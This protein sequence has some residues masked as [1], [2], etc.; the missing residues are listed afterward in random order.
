LELT[1]SLSVGITPRH[2]DPNA[3][4]LSS[5]RDGFEMSAE[6]RRLKDST[7]VDNNASGR[8]NNPQEEDSS[9]DHV[10]REERGRVDKNSSELAAQRARDIANGREAARRD[11]ARDPSAQKQGTPQP[12]VPT[13]APLIVRTSDGRAV[14]GDA[15]AAKSVFY[16]AP[17]SPRP[18]MPPAVVPLRIIPPQSAFFNPAQSAAAAQMA[19]AA[20]SSVSQSS[21]VPQVDGS[22]PVAAPAPVR[23][24]PPLVSS[25]RPGVYP[26]QAVPLSAAVPVQIRNAVERWALNLISNRLLW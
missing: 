12:L 10:V 19:A 13:K 7:T 11:L 4:T 26:S 23:P 3:Q 18:T 17:T 16:S 2:L 1:V 22:A 25:Q 9:H 20:M 14:A 6:L 15:T 24:L 8:R 5:E 21:S